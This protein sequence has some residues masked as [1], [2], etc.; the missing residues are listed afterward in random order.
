MSNNL[1]MMAGQQLAILTGLPDLQKEVHRLN[2]TYAGCL[3][4]DEGKRRAIEA[5]L[6]SGSQAS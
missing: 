5:A 2:E 3:L 4:F 6:L 1:S